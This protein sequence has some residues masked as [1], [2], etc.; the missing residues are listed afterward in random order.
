MRVK[1]SS[2]SIPKRSG[3]FVRACFKFL[4]IESAPVRLPV[5]PDLW[6]ILTLHG[7]TE[8]FQTKGA[9]RRQDRAIGSVKGGQATH[10]TVER[11][12]CTVFQIGSFILINSKRTAG[13][14]RQGVLFSV[15]TALPA[16]PKRGEGG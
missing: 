1:C 8:S 15:A 16:T 12:N 6:P 4:G 7:S 13:R 5:G 2:R 3:G 10:R 9:F 11:N 14:T